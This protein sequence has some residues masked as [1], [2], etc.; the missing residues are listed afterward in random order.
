MVVHELTHVVQQYHGEG[1]PGWLV[2]G[3]A[4]YVRWWRYE[5]DSPRPRFGPKATYHDSY[6]TTAAFLAWVSYHYNEALVPSLDRAMRANQDPVP[7]FQQ[8]TGKSPD[9]LWRE[10]VSR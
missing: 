3:I 1:Q 10:M 8:L 4:D 6:Q 7:V 2:E 9:D 5:P